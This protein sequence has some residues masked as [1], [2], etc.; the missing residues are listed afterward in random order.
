M[1]GSTAHAG[2]FGLNEF[3]AQAVGRG[4]ASAASNV[5]AS[6]I[7]YNVGGLAVA[8]GA[9]V[10]ITGTLIAPNESFTPDGSTTKTDSTVNPQPVPGVFLSYRI[11]KLIAAGVGFYTP[12]AFA[13]DWPSTSPQANVVES[14]TLRS[15]YVTPA[16]GLNLGDFV[17]GLS[18]GAGLD[19]APATIEL[20]QAI[21]FGQDPPGSGHLG[22]TA[23]GVGGRVGAMYRPASL[24]R[25][26]IGV[27]WHSNV[28]EKFSGTGN[29]ESL[30]Q[31]RQDLP[32]NG[33]VSTTLNL[34]QSFTG[35]VA[36]RPTDRLELEADVVWTEWS[37]LKDFDVVVPMPPS[38]AGTM[39]LTTPLNLQ[40][41]TSARVGVEYAM[42]NIGVNVRAG[43]VYDPS[44]VPTTTLSTLLPDVDRNEAC[45]GAS[46]WFGK[47][48][49]HLGLLYI[50]PTKRETSTQLYMP[51]NKADFDVSA[52]MASL[53]VTGRWH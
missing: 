36:Y 53:S 15:F 37:K 23:T 30:P 1:F 44:P 11:N 21:Y 49:V 8:P 19:I 46:K 12:Y 34:P 43:Y 22:A 48:A 7:F 41:T 17:P 13:V 52:F 5:E 27:T 47:Y 40:N 50:V 45:L 24:P 14:A 42:P 32:G 9:S 4:E 2:G 25:L 26:A 39:T 18:V 3:D 38:Q 33:D 29:F 35:G 28:F 6:S 20:Q 10:M 16:V 31:Y 51:V